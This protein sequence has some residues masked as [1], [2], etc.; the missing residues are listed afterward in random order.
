MGLFKS[1]NFKKLSFPK[2]YAVCV[3]MKVS[4]FQ[5][6]LVDDQTKTTSMEALVGV[7]DQM[8]LVGEVVGEEDTLAVLVDP[9]LIPVGAEVAPSTLVS[10]RPT[11]KEL[12]VVM[13]M[14]LLNLLVLSCET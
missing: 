7:E 4:L 10:S 3:L 5:V 8:E 13:A 12:I 9:V 2:D 6:E 14:L 1:F 11:S